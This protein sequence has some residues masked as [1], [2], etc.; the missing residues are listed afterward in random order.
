MEPPPPS[1][2]EVVSSADSSPRS[3]RSRTSAA[4]EHD[5]H[6]TREIGKDSH[7]YE[8]YHNTRETGKD[9]HIYEEIPEPNVSAV[10]FAYFNYF[11]HTLT[12][13]D[14]WFDLM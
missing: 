12:Y 4:S 2:D 5:Y 7:I 13:L 8:D 6:N 11:N 3:E 1:Y 9:S 14:P 10:L